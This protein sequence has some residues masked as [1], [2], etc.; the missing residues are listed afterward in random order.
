MDK[1]VELAVDVAMLRLMLD[2]YTQ[3]LVTLT[4]T[5]K[6]NTWLFREIVLGELARR[7]T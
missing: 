6:K 7:I 3:M 1:D 2:H 4:N 5:K